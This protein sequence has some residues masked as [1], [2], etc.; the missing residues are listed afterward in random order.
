[1]FC[2]AS[3]HHIFLSKWIGTKQ[4]T[5]RLQKIFIQPCTLNSITNTTQAY[6]KDKEV[7]SC[8]SCIWNLNICPNSLK[9]NVNAIVI[10]LQSD[11]QGHRKSA[12]SWY[13]FFL[14][15]FCPYP[16]GTSLPESPVL[17]PSPPKIPMAHFFISFK[18]LLNLHL[19]QKLILN[20]HFPCIP[21]TLPVVLYLL[22]IFFLY[23]IHHLIIY[24]I[25]YFCGVV[26]GLPPHSTPTQM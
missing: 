24:Y 5:I 15:S 2:L 22:Q 26:H 21:T 4:S 25:L 23:S 20:F 9:I 7:R 19:S 18:A 3:N 13:C 17:V 10:W 6:F 12:T 16:P 14:H 8:H 11:L 1:M